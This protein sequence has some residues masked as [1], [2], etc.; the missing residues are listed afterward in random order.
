MRIAR[1]ITLLEVII[2]VAIIVTIAAIT[3]PVLSNA[4]EQGKQAACISNLHQI[5]VALELYAADYPRFEPLHDN[6]RMPNS[7]MRNPHALVPYL[8]SPDVLFCPETPEC[9]REKL[10]SSYV[11]TAAPTP[12]S[13]LYETGRRQIDEWFADAGTG[14]PLVH[15][16][17]HDELHYYPGERHLADKLNP[18]FVIR[19]KIDGSVV[20]GRY[21]IHRGH[22]IARLCR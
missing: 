10:I 16:L 14:Y 4:K 17:V 11:W 20:K 1:G 6:V 22:D 18:P 5:Y 21:K 15:C 2:V 19:L 3:Y 13:P 7:V 8:G 9:A 12:D